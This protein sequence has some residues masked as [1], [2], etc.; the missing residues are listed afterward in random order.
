[1]ISSPGWV[2]L[3][4]GASGLMSTRFWTTS[5]PR[6]LRSCCWRSVRLIPDACCSVLLMSPSVV[7]WLPFTGRER[8]ARSVHA[9]HVRRLTQRGE[10]GS[11]LLSEELGLFPCREVAALVDLVEVAD[12]GVDR[13]DPAA[14]GPPDLAGERGEP[15][16]NRDLRRSLPGRLGCRQSSSILPVRPGRRGASAR[17]PVQRDVVD[18]RLPG[19]MARGLPLDEGAGDLVVAVR[20]VVEQPGGQGDG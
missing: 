2:C 16:L 15:D 8:R 5:R 13:I 12:V 1:M 20:V 18:D 3:K 9:A 10:C 7:S 6:M 19:E 17:Q 11:H 14:R 4:A